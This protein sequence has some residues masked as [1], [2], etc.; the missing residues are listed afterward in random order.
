M[1]FI[2]LVAPVVGATK[3]INNMTISSKMIIRQIGCNDLNYNQ[4][5][6]DAKK[7]EELIDMTTEKQQIAPWNIIISGMMFRRPDRKV[8]EAKRLIKQICIRKGYK[9]LSPASIS[10]NNFRDNVHLNE[11]GMQKWVEL[12]RSMCGINKDTYQQDTQPNEGDSIYLA[13]TDMSYQI[14]INVI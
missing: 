6:H 10:L 12:M 11:H 8:E 14:S 13:G 5:E 4:S 1:L 7:L 9:F 3:L 2:S